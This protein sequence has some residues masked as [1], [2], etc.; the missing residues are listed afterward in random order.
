MHIPLSPSSISPPF[1][2]YSHGVEVPGGQKLVFCSGQL[3]LAKDGTVP[4]GSAAQAELCFAN[5][6]AILAESGLGMDQIIR[7][8]A[9]VIGREHMQGYMDTRNARFSHPMPASTLMIV[10]GFSRPE[11]VVEI[12]AIAAGPAGSI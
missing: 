3:G 9:Y 4:P 7:L 1:S 2:A 5:I 11:F 6:E 12:E 8:N 10:G